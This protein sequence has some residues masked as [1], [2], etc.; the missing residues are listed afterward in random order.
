MSTAH[1]TG[2]R[3]SIEDD[4]DARA[5]SGDP[6]DLERLATTDHH[7]PHRILGAHAARIGGRDGCVVR[8]FHPDAR[9]A[10]CVLADGR[11]CEMLALGRGL[12]AVFIASLRP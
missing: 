6:E 12:F 2:T 5:L 10:E 3:I 7:D 9:R 11:A 8:C 1:K 4:A